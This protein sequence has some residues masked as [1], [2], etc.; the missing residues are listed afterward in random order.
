LALCTHWLA[1]FWQ[2]V[3]KHKVLNPSAVSKD[4]KQLLAVF[5]GVSRE[6]AL[7]KAPNSAQI[8]W[9]Y[10][11]FY[12]SRPKKYGATMPHG[13]PSNKPL[14]YVASS[15]AKFTSAVSQAFLGRFSDETSKFTKSPIFVK[16]KPDK[17]TPVSH[18]L[19]GKRV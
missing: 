10:G 11:H 9:L 14:S 18:M 2:C 16:E 17:N 7:N 5:S 19:V 1:D 13:T 15:Y 3:R 6:N 8:P 12:G 4:F